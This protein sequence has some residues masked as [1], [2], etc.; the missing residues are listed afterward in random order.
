MAQFE[1]LSSRS[2]SALAAARHAAAAPLAAEAA[3][4]PQ[5]FDDGKVSGAQALH[6]RCVRAMYRPSR[7]KRKNIGAL[8]CLV[9]H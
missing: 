1:S 3:D 9:A 2:S 7:S 8:L 5:D 6:S 4:A